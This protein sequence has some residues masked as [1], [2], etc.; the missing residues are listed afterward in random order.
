MTKLT[1]EFETRADYFKTETAK[2]SLVLSDFF[3]QN[4]WLKSLLVLPDFSRK[5]YEYIRD[6]E[7]TL[8][9]FSLVLSVVLSFTRFECTS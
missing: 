4:G 2:T 9:V 5:Y 1:K 8:Q 6:S 3:T 7:S